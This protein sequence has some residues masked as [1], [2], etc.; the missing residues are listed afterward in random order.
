MVIGPVLLQREVLN[1]IGAGVVIVD[2]R[3]RVI[4]WANPTAVTL[5]G[6]LCPA[7][8]R[9]WCDVRCAPEPWVNRQPMGVKPGKNR[10]REARFDHAFPGPRTRAAQ[11]N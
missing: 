2:P 3:T 7:I 1:R 10:S 11:K 5:F 4:A 6:A 9:P 8:W